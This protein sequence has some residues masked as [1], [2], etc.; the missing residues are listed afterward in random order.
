MD[1]YSMFNYGTINRCHIITFKQLVQFSC[2]SKFNSFT[3]CNS[4]RRTSPNPT[5]YFI[6]VVAILLSV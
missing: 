3:R 6:Q 2:L 1:P 4:S 5:T